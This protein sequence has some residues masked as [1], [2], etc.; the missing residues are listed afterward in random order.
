LPDCTDFTFDLPIHGGGWHP[1]EQDAAGWFSWMGRAA[2]LDLRPAGSGDRVLEARIAHVL[3]PGV[4]DGLEVRVNGERI[5]IRI[6]KERRAVL[7]TADVPAALLDARPDRV[8]IA[9][10]LREAPRP[11][12]LAPG[13]PDKRPLGAAFDRIRLRPASRAA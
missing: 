10:T 7:V 9:F 11:Y 12:D 5:A 8:R 2:W 6:R 1:R 13:N 3:A 4:L